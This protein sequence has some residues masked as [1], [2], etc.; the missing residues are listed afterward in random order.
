MPCARYQP[1][2]R[3]GS[4]RYAGFLELFDSST[5]AAALNNCRACER[6]LT[7]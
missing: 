1:V 5:A 4:E 3:G 7:L 2:A 6:V